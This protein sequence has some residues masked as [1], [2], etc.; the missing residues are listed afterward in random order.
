MTVLGKST[1]EGVLVTHSS[2]KFTKNNWSRDGTTYWYRCS[3]K[4]ATGCTATA[5]IKRV[6][7]ENSEG[8]MVVKN[9]LVEVSTPEVD[10]DTLPTFVLTFFV[11]VHAVFHEPDQASMIVDDLILQMKKNIEANPMLPVGK[12]TFFNLQYLI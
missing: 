10:V 2:F 4:K 1:K 11:K 9:Y 6:E 12:E 8:I 5:T 7:E 3:A